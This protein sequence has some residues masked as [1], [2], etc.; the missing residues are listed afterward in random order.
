M[1]VYLERA[2]WHRPVMT[3]RM[4]AGAARA[5]RRSIVPTPDRIVQAAARLFGERGFDRVSMPDIATASGITAGAIYKHF[6]SKDDLFF[7]VVRRAV[8]ATDL[9]SADL[10]Q[11]V[12]AY[13][14]AESALLRRAAVEIHHASAA[15]PKVRK[16]L[17]DSLD[18]RIG[19]LRDGIAAAQR[20]GRVAAGLD[21]DLLAV[22]TMVFILGL[23]HMETLAPHLIGDAR[24]SDF[25][26]GRVQAL[27]GAASEA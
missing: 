9:P 22:T 4:S 27:L 13:T 17:R 16:M 25:V 3:K 11:V 18:H 1:T 23:M 8:E 21:A 7:E 6:A 24:W 15:H 12:A 2:T 26:V 20:Q 19:Q 5:R 10:P 14:A